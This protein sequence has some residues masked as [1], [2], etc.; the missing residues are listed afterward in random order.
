MSF[1]SD[2]CDHILEYSVALICETSKSVV[3]FF[4]EIL[5][6]NLEEYSYDLI[7]VYGPT[8]AENSFSNGIY[9]CDNVHLDCRILDIIQDQIATC[10]MP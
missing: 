4:N 10:E 1:E 8:K 6:K 5:K 3:Q 7:D 9:H 2:V